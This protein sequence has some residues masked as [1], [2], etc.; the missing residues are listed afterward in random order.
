VVDEAIESSVIMDGNR[1]DM[2][3][4]AADDLKYGYSTDPTLQ[5]WT[6]AP[7]VDLNGYFYPYVALNPADGKYYC[8]CA[9][10]R[11]EATGIFMFVS[12]DKRN[13]SILNSGNPVVSG[14]SV[15]VNT[16]ILFRGETIYLMLEYG[17]P[18][19][20]AI[21]TSTLAVLN[22]NTNLTDVLSGTSLPCNPD[23]HYLPSRDVYFL[24]ASFFVGGKQQIGAWFA[25][26]T[27][28]LFDP[29]S[30]IQTRLSYGHSGVHTSD[31]HVVELPAYFGSRLLLSY[32][33]DQ[34][35]DQ[36]IRESNTLSQAFCSGSLVQLYDA[37]VKDL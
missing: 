2:W 14:L 6:L 24:I 26:G 4:H 15:M 34:S 7:E 9:D 8:T 5:D 18:R 22:F 3:Y 37:L 33:Y 10:D 20:L 13:W 30:W 32:N 29:L 28:D 11:T 27:S 23:L 12:E 16:S 21:A 1:V 35:S 25:P 36:A 17:S 31:P 19:R